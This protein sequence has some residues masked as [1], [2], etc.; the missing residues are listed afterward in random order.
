M[1]NEKKKEMK[2]RKAKCCF[3]FSYT[4]C[5]KFQLS[6]RQYVWNLLLW[7][8]NI[9]LVTSCIL[10]Y[11]I[12]IYLFRW[13]Q[14]IENTITTATIEFVAISLSFAYYS[15]YS[16]NYGFQSTNQLHTKQQNAACDHTLGKWK[17][18]TEIR[19]IYSNKI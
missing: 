18:E 4:K 19:G 15:I 16:S 1:F 2:T 9:C 17:R 12:F 7:L 6:T 10:L 14:Y 5:V 3:N 8:C 13:W 11:L